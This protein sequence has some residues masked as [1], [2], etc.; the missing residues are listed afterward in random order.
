M[1]PA[2]ALALTIGLAVILVS[3]LSDRRCDRAR[4]HSQP[5]ITHRLSEVYQRPAMTRRK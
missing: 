3:W 5:D 4:L 2:A 1:D